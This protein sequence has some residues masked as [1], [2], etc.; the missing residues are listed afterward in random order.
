MFRRFLLP[1]LLVISFA[2]G[3]GLTWWYFQGMK[4]KKEEQ[5]TILLEKIKNVS[6]LITVEGYLTEIY[7]YK[8]YYGYDWSPFRKKALLRVKAKVSVGVDLGNIDI[9]LNQENKTVTISGIP[10]PSILSIDHQVDYYDLQEGTFNN[11]TSDD[12]TRLNTNAKNFIRAKAEESELMNAAGE[13]TRKVIDMLRF[14][15]ETDGWRLEVKEDGR[16]KM[17]DGGWRMKDE[18]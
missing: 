3:I 10:A 5:A 15:V 2:A 6:K 14:L 12:I 16:W 7:D 1:L 13:Q 8:E 4:V 9:A 18:G 17:E 11:F